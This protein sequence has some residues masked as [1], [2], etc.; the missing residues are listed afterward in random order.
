MSDGDIRL[1]SMPQE[2][3]FSSESAGSWPCDMSLDRCPTS[4]GSG[5][6][7]AG[8]PRM[9]ALTIPG[10]PLLVAA[11]AGRHRQFR[12]LSVAKD[13]SFKEEAAAD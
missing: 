4:L 8:I 11:A 2:R 6:Y 3:W 12:K 9:G 10:I 7:R 1:F 13:G 5:D